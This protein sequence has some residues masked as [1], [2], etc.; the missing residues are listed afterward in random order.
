MVKIGRTKMNEYA[1]KN[2]IT[3]NALIIKCILIF[4]RDFLCI[5]H[6]KK[7]QILCKKIPLF[8]LTTGLICGTM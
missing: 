6:S 8:T 7:N 1:H 2:S 5:L 3:I 4:C